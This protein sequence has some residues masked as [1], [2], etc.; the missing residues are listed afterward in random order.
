MAETDPKVGMDISDIEW[1]LGHH[2]GMPM[3]DQVRKTVV[4]C[5][6]EVQ[7]RY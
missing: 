5:V 7:L 4:T 6:N 1:R 2:V 3:T